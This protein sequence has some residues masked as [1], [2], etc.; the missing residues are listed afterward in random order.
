MKLSA[1][2]VMGCGLGGVDGRCA[3]LLYAHTLS[4]Q[5]W[6]PN[7]RSGGVIFLH[8]ARRTACWPFRPGM[9]KVENLT[10]KYAG[11]T[12]VDRISFEVG[13]GEVVGFLG[14]NG[15]GKTSTMRILAGFMPATSGRVTVA[16]HDVFAESR[17]ARRRVG[18]L[19]ENTPLYAGMRVSEYLR[20]RAELKGVPRRQIGERLEDV[21]EQCGLGEA[22]NRIIGT[23]SKGMRQRVGLADALIHAPDIL[24]L[25]EPTIGLDPGQIRQTRELIR[26]LGRR[27]TVLLSTHILPEVEAVC[28]RVLILSRGRIVASGT[29]DTLVGGF[30]AAGV[31]YAEL[32]GG[33]A[34]EMGRAL[35]GLPMVREAQ[36]R[37]AGGGWAG[38]TLRIREGG[39]AREAVYDLA[40][41]RGWRLRELSSRGI[42]LEDVFV[43][44]TET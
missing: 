10:K 27:H 31:L 43:D 18:Y 4:C 13:S 35:R 41:E 14:P 2:M 15:A 1:V 12:A 7:W 32:G 28:G 8:S 22:R 19:P 21:T 11:V 33:E 3:S 37:D 5:G 26:S 30:R 39:D 23:L 38:F 42:S 6:F 29:V 17:E 9:I 44:L 40:R 25:D 34:E 24:I 20:F 36:G 16:G